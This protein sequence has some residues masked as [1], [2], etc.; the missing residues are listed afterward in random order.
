LVV[1]L[2]AIQDGGFCAAPA[3][4]YVLQNVEFIHEVKI[5]RK[6]IGTTCCFVRKLSYL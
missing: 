3:G 6:K 5:R 1:D 4:D 2:S